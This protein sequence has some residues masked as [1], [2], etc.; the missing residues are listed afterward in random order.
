MDLYSIIYLEEQIQRIKA[1]RNKVRGIRWTAFSPGDLKCDPIS[2]LEMVLL[3]NIG[4]RSEEASIFNGGELIEAGGKSTVN[5]SKL[6]D[7]LEDLCIPKSEGV[8]ERRKCQILYKYT[9]AGG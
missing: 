5:S 3:L 1:Q 7:V 4:K 2:F 6:R 8:Q 9:S